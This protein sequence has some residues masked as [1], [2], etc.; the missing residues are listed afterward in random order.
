MDVYG[1]GG[2][3][4]LFPVDRARAAAILA[5]HGLDPARVLDA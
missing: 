4:G 3:T 2:V 1:Y 5:A